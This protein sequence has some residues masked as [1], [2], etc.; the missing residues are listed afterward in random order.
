MN[1][2]KYIWSQTM[3]VP[4]G[5]SFLK[6]IREGTEH[7]VYVLESATLEKETYSTRVVVRDG[8]I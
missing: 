2:K 5:S 8:F 4:V 6:I 1:I 7:I 3:S